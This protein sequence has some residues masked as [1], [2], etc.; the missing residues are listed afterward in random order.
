M[1]A[2]PPELAGAIEPAAVSHGGQSAAS[3]GDP[4]R[5]DPPR[6][7]RWKLKPFELPRP[8]LLRPEGPLTLAEFLARPDP[9]VLDAFARLELD[10]VQALVLARLRG[11]PPDMPLSLFGEPGY[12]MRDV[13]R[14]VEE[15]TALGV[16]II[17]A[18]RK[19]VGLLLT[20]AL[21]EPA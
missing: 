12:R 10:E 2:E 15:G 6:C 7:G 5:A 18:E 8:V 9:A 16:R 1:S 13:V 19:L 20:E 17:D 4:D 3:G 14:H 21:R 11:A